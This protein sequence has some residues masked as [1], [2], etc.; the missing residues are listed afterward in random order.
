MIKNFKIVDLTHL[1]NHQI[2]TWNGEC[3]FQKKITKDYE[4]NIA[5]VMSYTC[6]SNAGTHID[7]PS[8]FVPGGRSIHELS[9]DKELC[10]PIHCIDVSAKAREDYYIS[11]EDLELY[12]KKYGRMQEGAVLLANTGWSKKWND[13]VRYRSIDSSGS[14]RCPGFSPAVIPIILERKL[15]GVGIDTFSPDGGNMDLPL[16]FQLLGAGKYIVENLTNLDQVPPFGAYFLAL[17]LKIEDAVESPVRAIAL[18]PD[19]L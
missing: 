12:E 13:P 1:L 10:V 16:H 17:P 5:R 3:G 8:H 18:L 15:A 19:P 2:P 6:I 7:S 14:V 9:L 11:S 4:E